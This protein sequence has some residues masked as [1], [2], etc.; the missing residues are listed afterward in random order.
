MG[1]PDFSVPALK[2]IHES[3]NNISLVVTQPDKPKGRG[4]KLSLTPVK[5]FALSYGYEVYQPKSLN[6]DESYEYLKKFNPDFFVVVAFGQILNKKILSIP[7]RSPINIHGSILPKYRGS[8]PIHRA[9]LNGESDTGITTMFMDE[10]MDTGDMLLK[11]TIEIQSNDTTST[12][13]D[14]LKDV[15]ADLIIETLENFDSITPEKQDESIAT[16]APMLTKKE[17]KINWSLNTSDIDYFVRGMTPWPGAFTFHGDKRLKIFSVKKSDEK[18]RDPPGT[19]VEC[20]D[21]L[22]IVTS[23]GSINITEIQGSSGKRLNISDFLRGYNIKNN[24]CLV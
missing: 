11:S 19:V 14:K 22:K 13:H 17:G 3:D 20:N 9:I 21:T 24:D 7:K 10:G 2:A 6:S 12:I 18:Y 8:A 4:K 1:T 23:D 16:Y 15:G 5:E